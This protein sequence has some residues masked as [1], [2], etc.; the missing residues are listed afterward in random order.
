L[1]NRFKKLEYDLGQL[2]GKTNRIAE[3]VED[4]RI[5]INQ[6]R[7]ERVIDS[8]IFRNIEKELIESELKFKKLLIEK[9]KYQK[10][11][12]KLLNNYEGLKEHAENHSEQKEGNKKSV[13]SS[14]NI[15][16]EI[17]EST[18]QKFINLEISKDN[19]NQKPRSM[20]YIDGEHEFSEQ[21]NIIVIKK[22]LSDTG[23]ENC[24]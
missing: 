12:E 17:K 5:K 1:E 11:Y 7:T 3:N 23:L 10:E 9:I 13:N 19:G 21:Q 14:L 8:G 18:Y 2:N 20:A 6:N 22:L 16:N 24:E 4:K 15:E